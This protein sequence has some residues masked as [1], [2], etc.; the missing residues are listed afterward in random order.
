MQN[1]LEQVTLSIYP[2]IDHIKEDIMNQG[3]LGC[4][5]SGSG[6]T[7]YGIFPD[8]KSAQRGYGVLK[9]RY[10]QCFVVETKPAGIEI[11]EE[12]L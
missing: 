4:C 3:A 8:K 6:P 5:M 10:S 12:V 11:M 2:E 7:A 1:V 9:E